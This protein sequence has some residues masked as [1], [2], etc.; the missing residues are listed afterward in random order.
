MMT[1]SEPNRANK[2]GL[3]ILLV[4]VAAIGVEIWALPQLR[5]WE[6]H[7]DP[8]ELGVAAVSRGDYSTAV[9]Y[10]SEK[11]AKEPGFGPAYND[12][13]VCHRMLKNYDQAMADLERAISL[14]PDSFMPFYNR[15]LTFA[16]RQEY[17]RAIADLDESLR[18]NPTHFPSLATRG[19]WKFRAGKSDEA[20]TD[21]DEAVRIAPR[22]VFCLNTRASIRLRTG[23]YAGAYE[24]LETSLQSEP[25]RAI[26][27]NNLAWLLSTCPQDDIRN[28]PK[29]ME[30]ANRACS[31][32]EWKEAG[33]IDTLA[34]ACA[35]SGKF[36]DA[37]R[38]QEM[39]I[40]MDAANQMNLEG[41]NARLQL[42]QAR[43][44]FRT[45][46][47]NLGGPPISP[48]ENR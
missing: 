22:D 46:A 27:H 36:D 15:A 9:R 40:A 4:A 8:Y 19:Q 23:R 13:A 39:T 32:S 38:W 2:L 25:E 11:I 47:T 33:Y 31:L 1:H 48:R 20:M 17:P 18:R 28:G 43:K 42:Y 29:S 35:E 26:T 16:D 6:K 5:F 41:Y 34:A 3:G 24:D 30:L 21:L 45:D 44:P 37:V 10:F 12:R 7:T 14:L